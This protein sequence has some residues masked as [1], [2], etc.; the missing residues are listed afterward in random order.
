M[1]VKAP[2]DPDETVEPGDPISDVEPPQG[3]GLDQGAVA[4]LTK[5]STLPRFSRWM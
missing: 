1:E 5:L 4:K 2:R 3:A